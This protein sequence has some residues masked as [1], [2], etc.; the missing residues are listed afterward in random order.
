MSIRKVVER[1]RRGLH[2]NSW[3]RHS[4]IPSYIHACCAIVCFCSYT[5][6][7]RIDDIGLASG[8]VRASDSALRSYQH[9]IATCSVDIAWL[10]AA[11]RKC[12]GEWQCRTNAACT[13]WICHSNCK[14]D[15]PS[16]AISWRSGWRNAT[17]PT[18]T[19]WYLTVHR[20][21][22]N[23]QMQDQHY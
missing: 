3:C 13:R 8:R 22:P 23:P 20:H 16:Y 14:T 5:S 15:N 7:A 17:I 11:S 19:R 2:T 4:S 6:S 10:A 1:F 12:W 9:I 21:W 18:Y